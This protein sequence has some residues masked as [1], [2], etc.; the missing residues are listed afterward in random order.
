LSD[1]I[2]CQYF[3]KKYFFSF[4]FFSALSA[5]P[6]AKGLRKNQKIS[7]PKWQWSGSSDGLARR[8]KRCSSAMNCIVPAFVRQS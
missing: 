4:V 6:W 3:V 5:L 1:F 8:R 2:L 7:Q